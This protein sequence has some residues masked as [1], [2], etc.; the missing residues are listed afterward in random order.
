MQA[1]GQTETFDI[2][3]YNPPKDW[4]KD[5]KQGVVNYLNANETRQDFKIMKQMIIK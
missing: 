3:I 5:A 1:I 4:K 2:I